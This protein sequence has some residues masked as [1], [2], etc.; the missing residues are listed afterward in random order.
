M[1][2]HCRFHLSV[3]FLLALVPASSPVNLS[4]SNAP[5]YPPDTTMTKVAVPGMA[6]PGYLSPI[7]DPIF[8]TRVTR[9]ADQSTFG[10]S[11]QY[12][13]HVYSKNQPWNSD[14]SLIMLNYIYPA[15]ILDGKTYKFLRRVRQPSQ[16]VWANTDPNKT[17]GTSV[18]KF[19]N[20]NM[21]TSAFT[22]L[23]TFTEYDK[24]SLGES[25][26]NLS[27]D[28]RY[29]ALQAKKGSNTYMVVYDILF[30]KVVSTRS[31]NGLWPDHI[32]MS[33]SGN[34]VVVSWNGVD[35]ARRNAG[36]EIFDRNLNF[37]R[38]IST[39][40]R[41]NDLG[42]DTS[43]NEVVVM[44]SNNWDAGIVSIRLDNGVQTSVLKRTS[45]YRLGS[46]WSSHISCRNT[47]RPGWCYYSDAEPSN[48]SESMA[49]QEIVAIKLD[50]SQTVKRFAHEHHSNDMSYGA[51]PM[52][53]SNRD[54][55]K[56]MWASEWNGGSSVPVYSYVAEMPSDNFVANANTR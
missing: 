16:A 36:L 21:T 26:G 48:Q 10:M 49:Y 9:I 8:K 4:Q 46:Y 29:V 42:Y 30:N 45:T 1:L 32:S 14:G 31:L 54:G 38:Q 3:F 5:S 43:G 19:V 55:S 27:I 35:G 40:S 53:V 2:K 51:Y 24:V 23:H 33:Q 44:R 13:R 47:K 28:D 52:A 12:V 34:Y 6:R 15:P 25:E 39:Y 18:N 11:N 20:V 17:Y 22:T 37:L 50:G 7:T 41:H 56:V